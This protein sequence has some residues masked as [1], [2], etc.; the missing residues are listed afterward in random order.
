MTP[1]PGEE[2]GKQ[3]AEEVARELGVKVEYVRLE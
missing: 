2:H 1:N 3:I